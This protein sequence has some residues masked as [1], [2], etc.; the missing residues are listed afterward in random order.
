VAFVTGC[1]EGGMMQTYHFDEVVNNEG[2]VTISGLPAYK[3]VQIVVLYPEP[4]DFQEEMKRWMDD[5]SQRHPFA[6]M[7]KEEV[8][9]HLRKTRE[10]VYEELYGDRYAD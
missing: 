1:Y 6:K 4:H 5:L 8:L 3:Q 2:V 10:E 7:S 9:K